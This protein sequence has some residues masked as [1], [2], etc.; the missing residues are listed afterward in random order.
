MPVER[1]GLGQ[2]PISPNSRCQARAATGTQRGLALVLVRMPSSACAGGGPQSSIQR[3]RLAATDPWRSR[4]LDSIST[5][6]CAIYHL[7]ASNRRRR[8]QLGPADVAGTRWPPWPVMPEHD[9]WSPGRGRRPTRGVAGIRIASLA[10]DVGMR[11]RPLPGQFVG[12]SIEPLTSISTC[13]AAARVVQG[14]CRPSQRRVGPMIG[15]WCHWRWMTVL[16][17]ARIRSRTRVTGD[18]RRASSRALAWRC[19]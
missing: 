14:V 18:G 10:A 11:S 4:R 19:R 3:E 5:C 9:R 16:R 17:A 1:L 7:R 2:V 13:G 8:M 6:S 12:D 15:F